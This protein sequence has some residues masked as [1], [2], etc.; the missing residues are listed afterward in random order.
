MNFSRT[1]PSS[2]IELQQHKLSLA[3]DRG[4][5]IPPSR[6]MSWRFRIIVLMSSKACWSASRRSG[7]PGPR[8]RAAGPARALKGG[9]PPQGPPGVLSGAHLGLA[10]SLEGMLALSILAAL[11]Q[12]PVSTA[13]NV[14]VVLMDDIGRDKV[15][16]YADHADAPPT[17]N[18]DALA[19]RGVLFRNAWAYPVCSPTRAALLVRGAVADW[20]LCWH[21]ISPMRS[22]MSWAGEATCC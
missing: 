20:V 7:D 22:A 14:V 2:P 6:M 16:A 12:G 10:A 8:Q 5:A 4:L 11:L 9:C 15:G 18:L 17:P 1:C 19:A 3:T 13:P 21:P